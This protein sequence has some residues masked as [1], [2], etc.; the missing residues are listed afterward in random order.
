M[1]P[2]EEWRNGNT[3]DRKPIWEA[4]STQY[5][6]GASGNVTYI[7]PQTYSNPESMWETVEQP[8]LNGLMKKNIVTEITIIKE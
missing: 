7:V 1:Y 3:L 6:S 8:I 5:A 2:L 4:L